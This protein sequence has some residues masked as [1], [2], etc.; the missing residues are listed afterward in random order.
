MYQGARPIEC[1]A[2]KDR[3]PTLV[4]FNAQVW[5]G[6]ARDALVVMGYSDFC[7]IKSRLEKSTDD[8]LAQMG[9]KERAYKARERRLARKV[10]DLAVR[11]TL[12]SY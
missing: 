2:N 10:D 7:K 6:K 4:E 1:L 8:Y 5:R 11:V 9:V 3:T 12:Y